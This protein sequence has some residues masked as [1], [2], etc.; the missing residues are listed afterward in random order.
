MNGV[1]MTAPGPQNSLAVVQLLRD[2]NRLPLDLVFTDSAN[3]ASLALGQALKYKIMSP[4]SLEWAKVFDPAALVVHQL[5]QRAPALPWALLRPFAQVADLAFRRVARDRLKSI[6]PA[7]W[8]DIPIDAA[9]FVDAAPRFLGD[10]R[11]RPEWSRDEFTWLTTQAAQRQSAGPLNFRLVLNGSDVPVG[12]YAFY[13]EKGGV[14]RV[15]H[16][17]ANPK[18]ASGLLATILQTTEA[19]GCI[20]AHGTT[21][22]GMLA[23]VY[24]T[25]GMFLYYAGGAMVSSQRADVLEAIERGDAFIGGFAGDR[26]TR[27]GTDTFGDV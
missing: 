5:R 23:Q 15:L 1:L 13:G 21:R 10:F 20:G 18:S 14:A 2:V 7:G 8:R 24:A 3:R 9:A 19:M 6:P 22:E 11:L 12:C 4:Q 17:G 26:W 25:P 16:A 27:L